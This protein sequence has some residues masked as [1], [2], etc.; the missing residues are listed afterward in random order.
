M[1]LPSNNRSWDAKAIWDGHREIIRCIVLGMNNVEIRE[2]LLLQG[3][4]YTVVQISNIRNS[5][6]VQVEVQRLQAMRND[7]AIDMKV[8]LEKHAPRALEFMSQLLD[9]DSA[10]K[11]DRLKAAMGILDRAGFAPAM[12]L[13]G[14]IHHKHEHYSTE[15][16]DEIRERAY[17]TIRPVPEP[18]QVIDTVAN[19]LANQPS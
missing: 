15:E 8:E 5:R 4:D 1:A 10:K 19:E 3:V 16:I 7:I 11:G 14:D 6:L 13:K 2:H 9:D 18:I 12:I 17:R